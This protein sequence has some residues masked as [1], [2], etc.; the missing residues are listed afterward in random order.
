MLI[1]EKNLNLN[2][3][4][5]IERKVPREQNDWNPNLDIGNLAFGND[6]LDNISNQNTQEKN[7]SRT[8]KQYKNYR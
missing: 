4:D 3:Q 7:K 6:F 1:G 5:L 8:N 2:H